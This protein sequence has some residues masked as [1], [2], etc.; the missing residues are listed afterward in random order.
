M[1]ELDD[2]LASGI[3]SGFRGNKEYHLGGKYVQLLEEE[4]R[5]YFGIGYAISFNSATAALHASLVACGVGA[6]NEVIVTPYSFSSSASCVLMV[7]AKPVFADIDEFTFNITPASI[8]KLITSRTKAIIPVHLC[9]QAA[10][11]NKITQLAIDHRL[12]II[13]D[14]AQAIT[15]TYLNKYVGT[16]GDCGVFSF[17]QSKHIN[18]G[19]GGMMITGNP[20][21]AEIARAVRNHGEV[22]VPELK[23]LGWNYRM[24]EIEAALALEQFKGID[25]NV[26]HRIKLA[27]Y[28]TLKLS[29]IS[30]IIPPIVYSGSKHVYYTYAI[31]VDPDVMDKETLCKRLGEKGVYFGTYVK[32]LHLLPIYRQFGYGEGMCPVAERMWKRELIV[33]DVIRPGATFEDMDKIV[34]AFRTILE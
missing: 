6:G 24:C 7:G 1:K 27:D 8:A 29:G 16:I 5:E 23:V 21:I 28:L 26:N 15:A 25:E 30:G 9:G 14:A 19:E 12:S 32:P 11:M 17:N 33:T 31:R 10:N 34:D 18:T 2:I 13:E 4:F 20:E 22:S 3:L